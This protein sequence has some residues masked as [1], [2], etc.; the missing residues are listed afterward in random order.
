MIGCK[1]KLREKLSSTAALKGE[2]MVME[3][4]AKKLAEAAAVIHTRMRRL[5]DHVRDIHGRL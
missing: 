5:A 1:Q 2:L 3:Y 4:D